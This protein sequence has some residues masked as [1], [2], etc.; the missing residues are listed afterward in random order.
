MN[1]LVVYHQAERAILVALIFEPVETEV[2]DN[3]SD[4]TMPL[5]CVAV[6]FYGVGIVVIALSRHYFPLVEAGRKALEVPFSEDGSLVAGFPEQLWESGLSTVEHAG[7]VVGEPVFMTMLTGE[8]ASSAG[9]AK[10]V[11]NETIG[12]NHAVAGNTVEIRSVSETLVVAAHHL[13]RMVVGHDVHYV[14]GLMLFLRM[15]VGARHR[16]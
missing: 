5:N 8:H 13:R 1:S 2:G 3:V 9:T 14:V 16:G 6:H 4:V 15:L 7:S 12:E 10:R 11:G